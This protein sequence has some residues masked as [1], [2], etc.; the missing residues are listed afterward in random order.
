[1]RKCFVI[2]PFGQPDSAIRKW[3]DIIY[4]HIIQPVTKEKGYSAFRTLDQPRP[5]E[6]TGKIAQEIAKADLVI[7]DLTG[8]NPNVMYELA[9]RHSTGKPFIHLSE[10]PSNIPFDILQMNAIKIGS[11]VAVVENAKAALREQINA[12]ETCE[13][14]CSTPASRYF[15]AQRYISGKAYMWEITYSQNL[16]SEWLDQQD[17]S[18]KE[19]ADKFIADTGGIPQNPYHRRLLAEYLAYK[20]APGTVAQGD[21][22]YHYS[23]RDARIV[24]GYGILRF[25]GIPQPMLMKIT[26]QEKKNGSIVIKFDQPSRRVTIAPG[27]DEEIMSFVYTITFEPDDTQEA[28]SGQLMHPNTNPKVKVGD[29]KLEL[30]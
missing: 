7:V 11:D 29:S 18:F 5:G 9:L 27:I 8:L 3:S 20:T 15:S 6:I 23:K 1:M 12:I 19:A 14:D 30:H 25:P 21:L 26:G 28:F 13:V 22:Y 24:E 10:D 17:H 2:S 16:P 4:A